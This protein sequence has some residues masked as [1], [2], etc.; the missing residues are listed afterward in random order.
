MSSETALRHIERILFSADILKA[1]IDVLSKTDDEERL[2]DLC[3][4]IP[5]LLREFLQV[6]DLYH[7]LP[8]VLLELLVKKTLDFQAFVVDVNERLKR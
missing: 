1:E 2:L 7:P 8:R 6:N 4:K 3:Q 5:P